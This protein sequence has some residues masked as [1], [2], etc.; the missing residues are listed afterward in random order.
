MLKTLQKN[1]F[2]DHFWIAYPIF[3][4]ANIAKFNKSKLLQT[5]VLKL[6]SFIKNICINANDSFLTFYNTSIF[7]NESYIFLLPFPM[8]KHIFH[9]ERSWQSKPQLHHEPGE[10][11]KYNGLRLRPRSWY[12]RPRTQRQNVSHH[13]PI[14]IEQKYMNWIQLEYII[15]FLSII[16]FI[17]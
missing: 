10:R 4:N 12:Y 9:S 16:F 14:L 6:R 8:T 17:I 13:L 3:F 2:N 1:I 11:L 5:T 15:F 7:H